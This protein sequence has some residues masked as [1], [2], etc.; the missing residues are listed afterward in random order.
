MKRNRS[1][2]ASFE[3][4]E[5][6]K[7]GRIK[8]SRKLDYR[9]EAKRAWQACEILATDRYLRTLESHIE[10]KLRELD[11]LASVNKSTPCTLLGIAKY[12]QEIWNEI[13]DLQAATEWAK[14]RLRDNLRSLEA[15][16]IFSELPV[17]DPDL[18]LE[19][20]ESAVDEELSIGL[21]YGATVC[22]SREK[23]STSASADS[24]ILDTNES[25]LSQSSSSL[26]AV[27]AAL[28]D[29]SST[30]LSFHG[31]DYDGSGEDE[32]EGNLPLIVTASS[33]FDLDKIGLMEPNVDTEESV[34]T[35]LTAAPTS[36]P[37]AIT[38]SPDCHLT[39]HVPE[40]SIASCG[41]VLGLD[42]SLSSPPHAADSNST[43]SMSWAEIAADGEEE[44]Q[45]VL[46]K[47]KSSRLNNFLAFPESI[48]E[49]S[50]S[51]NSLAIVPSLE[52]S[53]YQGD[54]ERMRKKTALCRLHERG[55][56]N[57]GPRCNYAHSQQE[58]EK[59]R[60]EWQ[61]INAENSFPVFSTPMKNPFF[62]GEE[63]RLRRNTSL[64]KAFQRG[65]CS[66][67]ERCNY[68]HSEKELRLAWENIRR[69]KHV[70]AHYHDEL[71]R[72]GN[73]AHGVRS[74]M[75]DA[76]NKATKKTSHPEPCTRQHCPGRLAYE[77]RQTKLCPSLANRSDCKISGCTM[78]HSREEL[79]PLPKF[80]MC[81]KFGGCGRCM[82]ASE[83]PY[84]HS[85]SEQR[86]KPEVINKQRVENNNNENDECVICYSTLKNKES[87]ELT[88]GHNQYH[89]SCIKKWLTE[90]RPD[91]P[92]CNSPASLP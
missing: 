76:A 18:T 84:A 5:L 20:I 36:C 49:A 22:M 35:D 66:W 73:K 78:A 83:C 47:D 23:S 15:G 80:E 6:S 88:C 25:G 65:E 16:K 45:T 29:L 56:C 28:N 21:S 13:T 62:Q 7:G 82:P 50:K 52:E 24:V 55:E 31:N 4:L 64:C 89:Y 39:T 11:S 14:I 85:K 9:M 53:T 81:S 77:T 70:F 33:T 27:T 63:G 10:C 37:G 86:K 30:P 48:A 17:I 57:W 87:T 12:R 59:A 43:T 79:R 74:N 60:K 19:S 42:E 69:H 72:E 67:G 26:E 71:R 58:V 38:D 92:L 3:E 54:E 41:S 46:K 40:Q 61:R 44:W 8:S 2:L 68:A 75:E 1:Q 90:R 91:C 34:F 51:E 32:F